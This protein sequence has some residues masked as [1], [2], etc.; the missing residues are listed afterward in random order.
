MLVI[1]LCVDHALQQPLEHLVGGLPSC[2]GCAPKPAQQGRNIS[3]HAWCIPARQ[4]R[5][6]GTHEVL[7]QS[8][9]EPARG[10]CKEHTAHAA[11]AWDC[12][13]VLVL[14]NRFYTLVLQPDAELTLLQA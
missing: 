7:K 13:H 2:D 12:L 6:G 8:G 3:E 4:G 1:L 5:V 11:A 14:L 9:M 10:S